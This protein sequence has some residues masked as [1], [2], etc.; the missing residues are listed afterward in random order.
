LSIADIRLRSHKKTILQKKKKQRLEQ[1]KTKQ[2]KK[3][4]IQHARNHEQQLRRIP[5]N[6]ISWYQKVAGSKQRTPFL[7]FLLGFILSAAVETIL[8]G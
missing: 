2:D 5:P 6:R 3:Q 1:E 7:V 4:N 8:Y